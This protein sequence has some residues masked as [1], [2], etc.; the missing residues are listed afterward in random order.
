MRGWR[1][2]HRPPALPRTP[3]SSS[4]GA[5]G[6]RP[7]TRSIWTP[8][9]ANYRPRRDDPHQR[10]VLVVRE[11]AEGRLRRGH[12]WIFPRDVRD[13][14]AIAQYSPCLA[15]VQSSDGQ[16]LGVALYNR[17]GTITARMLSQSAYVQVDTAFFAERLRECLAYRERL[18]PEPF[19]RLAHGEADGLPGMVVDRYGDHVSLQ[20]TAAGLDALLWP[21][22]DAVEEVLRPKVVIIR[23]DA[24][25]RKKERAPSRREVLKG[26]YRGPTELRE[27]GVAF[28]VDLLNG[29]KTGWYF[30]QRDHRALLATL[31][32]QAP[33][34]LDLYSYV[35]GFGVTMAQYGSSRVLC[36]DSSEAALELCERAA[37]MNSVGGR[38][39]TRCSDVDEFLKAAA[40]ASAGEREE[41]DLVVLDPPNLGRDRGHVPKALRYYE[42]LVC[43][44][45]TLCARPGM[46]FVASCTFHVGPEDLLGAVQRALKWAGRPAR[47]MA[48]GGQAAD[49]PGHLALPESQYLHSLLLYLS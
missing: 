9:S 16:S 10:P 21:L 42:R 12:P 18:F 44:A 17:H 49:H 20:L 23:Q 37:A 33:R 35:G 14:E 11:Q 4:G 6:G 5:A 22:A 38:V 30:D 39:E 36:V 29:H 26:Q 28:A 1:L 7:G 34:V 46:L 47:I 2:W 24:P 32:A 19:Y 31:A 3:A 27:N 48:T 8:G 45:A 25:G 40:G 43:S 41:F 15:N 13:P